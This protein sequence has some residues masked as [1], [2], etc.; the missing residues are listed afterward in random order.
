MTKKAVSVIGVIVVLALV[1]FAVFFMSMR[2]SHM[3]GST[4][5]SLPLAA[6]SKDGTQIPLSADVE[7]MTGKLDSGAAAQKVGDTIIVLA[8]D[9]YPAT[10]RQPTDFAVTLMD[11]NGQAINDAT[12]TLDL[13]MPEMWMPPNQPALAFTSD[14]KYQ[15]TGQ[16]TM[17]GW[18]RIEVIVTRGGQAQSA[19]FDVGL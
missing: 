4:G 19:F 8:M 13:T 10:M 7:A 18:W 17:R 3:M 1:A 5:S 14:G 9:P 2:R 15:A 6:V 11:G 16:F 12:V